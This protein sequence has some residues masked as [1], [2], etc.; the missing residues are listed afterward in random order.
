[1]PPHYYDEQQTSNPREYRVDAMLRG[2]EYSFFSASGIFSMKQVDKGTALLVDG[3]IIEDGWDVLDLGCG[4]GAVG[5]VIA[6]NFS[7]CNVYMTDVNKRAITLSKKNIEKYNLKHCKVIKGSLFKPVK[8]KKFDTILVNPP[9][10]AGRKLIFEMIEQSKEY[11]NEKG[12]LQVVFRHQKGGKV[13][14]KKMKDVFGNVKDIAKK[15]GYR[16]YVSVNE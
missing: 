8:D 3:C 4:Y 9:Y 11:L 14:M 16:I 6:D 5:I 7:G 1:M 12:L 13:V 10:V 15:S 2:K